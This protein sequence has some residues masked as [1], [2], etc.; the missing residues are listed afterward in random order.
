[1]SSQLD[2]FLNRDFFIIPLLE[3]KPEFQYFPNITN[4]QE[5]FKKIP[6]NKKTYPKKIVTSI[7]L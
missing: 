7:A 4:L 3:I 2:D 1:M 5:L 6:E